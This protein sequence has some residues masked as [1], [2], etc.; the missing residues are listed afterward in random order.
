MA[1]WQVRAQWRFRSQCCQH[2]LP[3]L[4]GDRCPLLAMRLRAWQTCSTQSQHAS[5]LHPVTLTRCASRAAQHPEHDRLY[6]ED[7]FT[8]HNISESA[9]EVLLD[10]CLQNL[11]SGARPVSC[12]AIPIR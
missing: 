9:L 11:P 6:L 12:R 4:W 1:E 10:T 7:A 5:T 8:S 3:M 2:P